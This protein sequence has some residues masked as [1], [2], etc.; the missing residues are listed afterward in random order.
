MTA[1]A[2]L[3]IAPD[4]VLVSPRAAAALLQ[5]AG[6]REIE[7]HPPD[8]ETG[9][10]LLALRRAARAHL[11]ARRSSHLTLDALAP[12]MLVSAPEAARVVGVHRSTI[13]RWIDSGRLPATL[14]G[15]VWW[16]DS[17]HLLDQHYED[18][19]TD[20]P[21]P[22]EH[23]VPKTLTDPRAEAEGGYWRGL[24]D[25]G[26]HRAEADLVARH[27]D[28]ARRIFRDGTS[29][30]EQAVVDYMTTRAGAVAAVEQLLAAAE[31]YGLDVTDPLPDGWA[32]PAGYAETFEFLAD[33]LV[34]ARA[35]RPTWAEDA[36]RV[37]DRASIDLTSPHAWF[38]TTRPAP[39]KTDAWAQERGRLTADQAP[40]FVATGR[41]AIAYRG[42][43]AHALRSDISRVIPAGGPVHEV[44]RDLAQRVLAAELDA[45][46][47]LSV[48][49]VEAIV[50]SRR[51]L[52]DGPEHYCGLVPR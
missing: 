10:A 49:E 14:L 37:G 21:D 30:P 19:V 25:R 11:D 7:R 29:S 5:L 41:V 8:P 33:E 44:G 26:G 24:L 23:S 12:A 3:P 35:T 46:Q 9:A 50:G 17:R 45:G 38:L 43:V 48:P 40:Y 15:S 39:W 1:R 16:V 4:G 28:R 13:V 22:E 31:Q 27:L 32:G 47:L 36:R 51:A 52:L 34:T 2:T 18:T 6:I 20:P 42:D